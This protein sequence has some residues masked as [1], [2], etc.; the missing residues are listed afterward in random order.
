MLYIN[1]NC[2]FHFEFNYMSYFLIIFFG[3]RVC[4]V[5]VVH[6]NENQYGWYVRTSYVRNSCE[7]TRVHAFT[8]ARLIFAHGV[9][10]ARLEP[11]ETYSF[12]PSLS[13]SPIFFLTATGNLFFS[14]GSLSRGQF[15]LSLVWGEP[16]SLTL[17]NALVVDCSSW[18]LQTRNVT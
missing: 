6:S 2:N 8:H 4:I 5:C 14:L 16:S 7:R 3:G 10:I 1:Y 11:L 12:I 13:A 17:V 18:R 15:F 9:V